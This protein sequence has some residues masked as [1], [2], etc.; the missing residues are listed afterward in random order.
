M[1][2]KFHF[3]F[4]AIGSQ[5]PSGV[6]NTYSF[7]ARRLLEAKGKHEARVV[8]QELKEK[9]INRVPSESTF[10]QKFKEIKYTKKKTTHRRLIQYIYATIERN[11]RGNDEVIPLDIT[12][13]HITPQATGLH[14]IGMIGNLLPLGS[15]GNLQAKTADFPKK[16]KVYNKSNFLYTKKFCVENNSVDSWNEERINS[17]TE[18]IALLAYNT[19][20]K[21]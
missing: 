14:Y 13:E 10:V 4:N 15:S 7:A 12:L 2:E 21:I 1:I 11:I 16:I 19:V 9:L 20:W 8:L 3:L 6:E 5:R 17:K 18:E